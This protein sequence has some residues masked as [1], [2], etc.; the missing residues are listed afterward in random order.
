MRTSRRFPLAVIVASL[1]LLASPSPATARDRCD[2]PKR[3]CEASE[4]A[5]ST[6]P[7]PEP[8]PSPDAT[9]SPEPSTSPEPTTSPEPSPTP[10]P[11]SD[12]TGTTT[13]ADGS[14]ADG[15]GASVLAFVSSDVTVA[16]SSSLA[17]SIPL[18]AVAE[19]LP[20]ARAQVSGASVSMIDNS[21]S[22]ASLTVTAGELVRWT[23]NGSLPH[24]ATLN[25][26]FDSGTLASGGTFSYR[27]ATPGT[28]RY[29]CRLHGTAAGL[30]MAGVVEVLGARTTRPTAPDPAPSTG[31]LA[32][33]GA[34][35]LLPFRA[36]LLFTVTGLGMSVAGSVRGRSRVRR[37]RS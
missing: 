6:T 8:S 1:F 16:S 35:V 26:V 31:S 20:V 21:F 18:D 3:G 34:R 24:T 33:T 29:Y 13:G 22:P 37:A 14:G 36:G 32:D 17:R 7:E 4:P 30:G 2:K 15:S 12:A 27:F 5:P 11:T 23:N 28:F 25:G 10:E 9:G 19:V